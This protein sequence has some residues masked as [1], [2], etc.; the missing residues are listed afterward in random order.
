MSWPWFSLVSPRTSRVS[1]TC[2][3]APAPSYWTRRKSAMAAVSGSTAAASAVV[4]AVV[5]AAVA[6]CDAVAA[7]A[8]WVR[9]VFG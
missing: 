1:T 7:A 3:F 8:T 2:V 9:R 5:A 6:L 4:A